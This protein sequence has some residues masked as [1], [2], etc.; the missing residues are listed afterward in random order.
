MMKIQTGAFM[1]CV[2]LGGHS[3]AFARFTEDD[4]MDS[5]GSGGGLTQASTTV[6][7][8]VETHLTE[9]AEDLKK[10]LDKGEN[11]FV[12][13]EAIQDAGATPSTM[14]NPHLPQGSAAFGIKNSIGTSLKTIQQLLKKY[15]IAP[16][17]IPTWW[18]QVSESFELSPAQP[19][20]T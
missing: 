6:D 15:L 4:A 11:G 2:L 18:K 14:V 7:R 1:L 20:K 19:N 3:D 9:R 17:Q 12:A 13:S 10:S 5:R 16:Q 8:V